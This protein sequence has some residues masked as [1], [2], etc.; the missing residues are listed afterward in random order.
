MGRPDGLRGTHGPATAQRRRF[1]HAALALA[2]YAA[3]GSSSVR[4]QTAP[5]INVDALG[6]D[7]WLQAGTA[8]EPYW[9]IDNRW[10]QGSVGASQFYQGVGAA[11]RS[12][13][14]RS[15]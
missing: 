15:S 7:R 12:A 1:R 13:R 5:P 9:V 6:D 14:G 4:G 2:V 10:G 8:A 3:F 11:T